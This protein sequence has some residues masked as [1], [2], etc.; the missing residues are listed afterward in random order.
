MIS[1]LW[2]SI[3][4]IIYIINLTSYIFTHILKNLS[5]VCKVYN[6]KYFP[7]I[8]ETTVIENNI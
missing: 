8:N 3:I 4:L 5:Y 6:S 7:S 1:F 2:T